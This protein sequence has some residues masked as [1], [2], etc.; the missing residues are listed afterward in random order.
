MQSFLCRSG[1]KYRRALFVACF[2]LAALVAQSAQAGS[3]TYAITLDATLHNP[4]GG[5]GGN[6]NIG[7]DQAL[8][9][10]VAYIY[11]ETPWSVVPGG[12]SFNLTGLRV[13]DNTNG[14]AGSPIA[15]V[16]GGLTLGYFG[17]ND[18]RLLA[19][20]FGIPF[21]GGFIAFDARFA[22]GEAGDPLPY[23][24][25]FD[26]TINSEKLDSLVARAG[27]DDLNLVNT[28]NGVGGDQNGHAS[29]TFI[30]VSTRASVPEPTTLLLFCLGVAGLGF[31]R[32]GKQ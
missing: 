32:R 12:A 30:F 6:L 15:G 14:L 1:A 27:D 20:G 13:F 5:W 22:A 25:A 9:L 4:T 16:L 18:D 23:G 31:A 19:S 17:A 26:A 3:I 29:G 7:A 24:A 28:V 11:D 10:T 2:S 8:N 21:G